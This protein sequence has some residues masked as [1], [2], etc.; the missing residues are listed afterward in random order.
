MLSL[1]VTSSRLKV[2]TKSRLDWAWWAM[3]FVLATQET[4]A[5]GSELE[6][7]LNTILGDHASPSLPKVD[8][9]M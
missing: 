1:P 9:R 6:A 5:G 4:E 8:N 3:S 2:R 7:S